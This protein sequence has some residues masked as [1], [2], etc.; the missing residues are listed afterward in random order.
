[1]NCKN[2]SFNEFCSKR[3]EFKEFITR[4]RQTQKDVAKA[5]EKTKKEIKWKKN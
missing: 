3:C 2:C 5:I 4:L 1:M